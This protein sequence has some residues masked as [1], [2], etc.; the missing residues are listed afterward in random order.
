MSVTNQEILVGRKAAR[1][2]QASIKSIIAVE[3]VKSTGALMK[4]RV[5]AKKEKN[6]DFL[7]RLTI[8]SPHYGFKLNYGFEGVKSNGVQMKLKPIN[9]LHRAV[10]QTSILNE[11]ATQISNI[12]AEEIAAN[13]N[14]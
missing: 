8:S 6:T 10:E 5:I 9:H 7:D 1:K 12:R 14:F 2:L 4:S 3:T 11:L 13:I